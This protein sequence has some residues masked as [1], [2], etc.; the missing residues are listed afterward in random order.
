MTAKVLEPSS[1]FVLSRESL[2]LLL[3]EQ[4]NLMVEYMKWL[5]TENL[6]HQ[7][8]LRDLVLNGKRALYFQHS[9]AFQILMVSL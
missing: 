6:K 5:Q 4:P 3:V 2:E 1:L 9:S 8:R 7:S